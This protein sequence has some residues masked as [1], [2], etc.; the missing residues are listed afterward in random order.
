MSTTDIAQDNIPFLEKIMKS[1]NLSDLYEAR[2]LTEIVYRTM[3]DLM[4]RE[5]IEGVESEL[6]KEAVSTNNKALQNE[7]ADLWKD[8]NPLVA[9]LSKIR[10][11]FDKSA[12][13]GIDDNL[14]ITRIEREGGMPAGNNGVNVIKAVFAA[15]KQELSQERVQE[16]SDFLPGKI[17]ELWTQA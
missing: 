3:R 17:Q 8:S 10:P 6:H 2:D 9:W 1:A 11:K 4:P 16:I 5:T 7:I 13:W 12:P 15:T 14:F